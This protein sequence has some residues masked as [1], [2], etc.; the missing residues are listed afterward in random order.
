MLQVVWPSPAPP[1]PLTV[2]AVFEVSNSGMLR[3]LKFG[4]RMYCVTHV[5]MVFMCRELLSM[6]AISIL[7]QMNTVTALFKALLS[8]VHSRVDK[9]GSI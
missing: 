9:L 7:T 8:N 2:M 4:F 5:F 6:V 3:L 1:S